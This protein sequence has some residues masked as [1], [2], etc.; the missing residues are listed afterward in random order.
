MPAAHG[1]AFPSRGPETH[2]TGTAVVIVKPTSQPAHSL[3]ERAKRRQ[4]ANGQ[5]L[6]DSGSA[7]R[8]Q[9]RLDEALS[10]FD[11][12]FDRSGESTE[13]NLRALAA[14]ALIRKGEIL[15]HEQRLMKHW[16]SAKQS[17]GCTERTMHR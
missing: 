13:P 7:F 6:F 8:E 9:G 10:A 4:E 12:V 2:R 17:R 5:E 3:P 16:I 1:G 15:Y 14:K 11:A